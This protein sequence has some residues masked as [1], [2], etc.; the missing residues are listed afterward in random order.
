MNNKKI[1]TT[2][3]FLATTL[4]PLMICIDFLGIGVVLPS[5]AKDLGAKSSQVHWLITMFA[6]GYVSLI[7]SVS[8][9]AD[10]YG[11]KQIYFCTVSIF[12]ISSVLIGL[13]NGLWLL[14]IG[15]FFQ[16]ASGGAMLMISMGIISSLFEG[17]KRATWMGY[18]VGMAGFGMALGP[19]VAG[20]LTEF[21]SW[22]SLFFANIPLGV[23]AL[24]CASMCI[25]KSKQQTNVHYDW[26]GMILITIIYH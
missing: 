3:L 14:I 8:R 12:I 9:V 6:I 26:P 21:F 7:I 17:T 24:T 15:R 13:S 4:I 16:G 22:R 10:K 20:F 1:N 25:P 11:Y 19:L 23:L 18:V 2:L 5:I